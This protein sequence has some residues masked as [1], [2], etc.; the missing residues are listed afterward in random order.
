MGLITPHS[1]IIITF[2][3]ECLLTHSDSQ[4]TSD[5]VP[6]MVTVTQFTGRKPNLM[7]QGGGTSLVPRPQ[8]L[9]VW[10]AWERG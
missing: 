8:K 10:K 2:S 1:I 6:V 4:I 7:Y 5:L 3:T 9:E